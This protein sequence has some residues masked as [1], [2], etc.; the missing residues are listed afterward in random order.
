M[1]GLGA[2]EDPVEELLGR[3]TLR[4]KVG[5][6]NQ[7][8][9]GWTGIER[10]GDGYRL[11]DVFH[12]EVERWGGL[13]GL[14]GVFRSDAW[15]GRGWHNGIEPEHRPEVAAMVIE[16]VRRSSRHGIGPL[17]VEEAPHGH[18]SLGQ[19]LFPVNLAAAATWDPELVREGADRNGGGAAAGRRPRGAD[20]GP[21]SAA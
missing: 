1:S 12:A 10:H 16:A 14:Y 8:L 17:L 20:L 13:G 15:S 5:Q 18:Q 9:H 4:E 7:R 19:T 11:T 6:L 3:L 21:G 2:R